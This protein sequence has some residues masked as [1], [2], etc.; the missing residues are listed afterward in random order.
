MDKLKEDKKEEN[1]GKYS[2]YKQNRKITIAIKKSH[3]I[4]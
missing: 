2:H 3:R 1:F 4:R